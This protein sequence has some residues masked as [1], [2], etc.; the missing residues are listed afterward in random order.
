[1]LWEAEL[2]PLPVGPCPPLTVS[3]PNFL[4]L[5]LPQGAMPW[6]PPCSAFC[7]LCYGKLSFCLFLPLFLMGSML[8]STF[9]RPQGAALWPLPAV[10]I[11][12][13]YAAGS[14]A[15][16]SS[17]RVFLW[18]IHANPLP[19]VCLR[20]PYFGPSLLSPYFVCYAAGGWAFASSHRAFS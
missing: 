9:S 6:A 5:L 8:T 17:C 12:V 2:L 14:W 20:E 11:L 19:S 7:V 13:C 1:M 15:L 16:A 18:V 4:V 10:P 3:L